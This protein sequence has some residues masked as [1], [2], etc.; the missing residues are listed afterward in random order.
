MT[1]RAVFWKRFMAAS[2]SLWM[3]VCQSG[4]SFGQE[5]SSDVF[6]TMIVEEDAGEDTDRSLDLNDSL[7][8]DLSGSVEGLIEDPGEE[9][10]A[11]AA[12][13]AS[14]TLNAPEDGIAEDS[15]IAAETS[16]EEEM[17]AAAPTEEDES[18]Q[19]TD[20]ETPADGN[21]PEAAADGRGE[22]GGTSHNYASC[23]RGMF[24][25]QF[26]LHRRR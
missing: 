19:K 21:L 7:E 8:S 13:D 23:Q 22:D 16:S 14:D 3:V 9:A 15:F 4:I 11:G 5:V 17:E 18:A 24:C 10:S 26:W 12:G 2:L 1:R 25:G 6:D 20:A